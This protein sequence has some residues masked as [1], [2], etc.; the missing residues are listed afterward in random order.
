M[1]IIITISSSGITTSMII[2]A[3]IGIPIM[4][5]VAPENRTGDPCGQ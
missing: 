5:E 3:E 1:T 4:T 2:L